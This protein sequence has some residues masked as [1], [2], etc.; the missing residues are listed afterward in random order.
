MEIC[1]A[2]QA[3]VHPRAKFCSSCGKIIPGESV[4]EKQAGEKKSGEA[5]KAVFILYFI[6]L[7]ICI[8]IKFAHLGH[9]LLVLNAGNF[10]ID[11][12]ILVFAI[13]NFRELKYNFIQTREV[14][15]NYFR[16]WH[17]PVIMIIAVLAC[18]G[19]DQ[20]V[21]LYQH[22]EGHVFYMYMY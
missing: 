9:T 11:A 2:C 14:R 3:P 16:L 5:L 15:W 20:L 6:V 7:L 19:V 13:Y 10:L 21:R 1:P 22:M 18:L 17:F 8:L 4:I 12:T